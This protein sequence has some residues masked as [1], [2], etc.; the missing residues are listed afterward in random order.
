MALKKSDLYA[1]LWASCDEL[2]GGMDASQYK[3]YVLFMLFIKYISDKYGNTENFASPVVI[4]KGASFKN[5][6]ALKGNPDIGNKINTEI[7]QPLIN[8]NDRLSSSDFPD[9]ND[10]AKLGDGNDRV[11]RLSNLIA[12]FEKPE[13]N[14]SNNRAENDDILGDA[15]E[16][17]MKNFA[18]ESGKS[19]GQFYTPSEVSRVMAKVIGISPEN[20]KA[21]TSVYDPTCG[22]GSLLLKIASE[23]GKQ[24]TLEGQERDVTTAGLARMNMILHNFPTAN[25]LAGNTL[26]SPKFL[27]ENNLRTYDYVVANPPF[28]SKTWSTGFNP[29]SD[30]YERFSWGTPPPKQGDY[31]FLLHIIRSMK[32]S[33]KAVCI[34]PHGV[35]FRGN[36]EEQ[37]RKELIKSGILKAVIGLPAN[38]FYGTGIPACILVLDKEKS[39][40]S[41]DIMMI[42]AS[43][44]F[45]KDGAKNRLREQDVHKIVDVYNKSLEIQNYSRLVK[46][47]EISSIKNEYNLNL[48]RYIDSY[49]KEDIHDLDAHLEGGIPQNDINDLDNYWSVFKSLKNLLFKNYGREGYLKLNVKTK[50]VKN[51]IFT[52]PEFKLFN[53]KV[54]EVFN[55][56]KN[57]NIVKFENFGVNENPKNLIKELSEDLLTMFKSIPIINEYNFYQHLMNYWDE[58]MQDDCY[59][60]SDNGWKDSTKPREVLKIKNVNG[61]LTWP[62]ETY[63]YIKAKKR[64]KSDLI[65]REILLKKYFLP[66]IDKLN[67]LN[68]E[69]AKLDQ[70]IQDLIDE[71]NNEDALLFELIEGEGDKQKISSKL[72]KSRIKEIGDNDNSDDELEILN[73]CLEYFEKQKN[74]KEE[75]K[76]EQAELDLKL[77]KKYFDL[78]EEEIKSIIIHDKWLKNISININNELDHVSQALADRISVL[79]E[80]YAKSLSTL[81]NEAKEKS[82]MV[83][84]HLKKIKSK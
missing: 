7:I 4:P 74:Y 1:S 22:S 64:Y 5:M 72:I 32:S 82:Q 56:W 80:R 17:L 21:N 27:D 10:P 3:D 28:S 13:L 76:K 8:Q 29:S 16:Y 58:T 30:P 23:A 61:K 45:K 49:D 43:K 53:H 39:G 62:K 51:K 65:S 79:S 55:R 57:N 19:K 40:E 33:G 46:F 63:D 50:E 71:H 14:F 54:L 9:F 47:T 34:L 59:L 67:K 2:R 26:S 18:T 78:K 75:I 83:D 48:S 70:L 77:E 25:I 38:L 11:E 52:H 36:A 44:D 73:K 24:I 35:L 84:K 81:E 69:L 6:V 68:I 15:Y 41:K 60:I 66:E 12:I 37:I 42:N 31:A 20:S